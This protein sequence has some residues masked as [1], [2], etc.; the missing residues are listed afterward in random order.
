[1]SV[2]PRL[3]ILSAEHIVA[4]H[5]GSLKVLARTGVLV[6]SQRALD[7]FSKGGQSI[8][9]QD[10]RVTFERD[11]VEWAIKSTPS[12]YDVFNRRGEKMFTLGDGP[13]RF[14]NGVTN[15]FYQDPVTDMLHPFSRKNM[16]MGVRLADSLP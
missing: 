5:E 16:E 10:N 7:V 12:T 13:A 2:H 6:E 8:H 1:M 9:I 4:I 3:T 11:V 14:G 15:L